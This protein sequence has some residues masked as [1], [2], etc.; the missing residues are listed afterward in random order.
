L[1]FVILCAVWTVN[2]I[3]MIGVELGLIIGLLCS[4]AVIAPRLKWL[5]ELRPPAKADEPPEAAIE[6]DEPPGVAP[7]TR[8]TDRPS[9]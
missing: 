6:P 8:I 2:L 7:E 4:A 9:R 3:M 5:R 1:V